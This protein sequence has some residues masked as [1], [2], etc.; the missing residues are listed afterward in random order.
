MFCFELLKF[1]FQVLN[2]FLF[3]FAERALRGSILGAAT[4]IRVRKCEW[5]SR[6]LEAITMRIFDTLSLSCCVFDRLLRRSSS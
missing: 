1:V 5:R 4:L 2:V 3:A 6:G